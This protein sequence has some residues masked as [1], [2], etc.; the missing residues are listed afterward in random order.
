MWSYGTNAVLVLITTIDFLMSCS[1]RKSHSRRAKEA[2]VIPYLTYIIEL[3]QHIELASAAL[4]AFLRESG[5]FDHIASSE[6]SAINLEPTQEIAIGRAGRPL[7]DPTTCKVHRN[8]CDP[9]LT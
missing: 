1:N 3:K 4:A 9:G 5:G 6:A 7:K 8:L 2:W